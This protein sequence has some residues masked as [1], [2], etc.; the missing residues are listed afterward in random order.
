MHCPGRLLAN[1]PPGSLTELPL[2]M[3]SSEGLGPVAKI[4]RRASSGRMWKAL[5]LFDQFE[6]SEESKEII[7]VVD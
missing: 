3:S 4:S 2:G 1:R 6:T 7:E 5:G